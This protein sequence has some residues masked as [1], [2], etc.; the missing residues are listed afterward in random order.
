MNL[1]KMLLA[2]TAVLALSGAAPALAADAPAASAVL[3]TYGD[4][5]QAKYEDALAGA[6]ALNVAVD[7]LIANPTDA[8]LA[9]A[10][11]AWKASRP[12]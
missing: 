10:R 6:K 5:A 9:A 11:D 2:A 8:T 7:A 3:K 12:A 1:K 4:I